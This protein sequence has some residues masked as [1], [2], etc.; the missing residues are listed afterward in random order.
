MAIIGP[1]QLPI[2][3]RADSTDLKFHILS[4]LGHPNVLVE[5]TE[6]QLEQILRSTAD[7]ISRYW[8]LQEKY[9]FFMTTP[10][11][12][13]YDIP[14][15]AYWIREVSWNPTTTRID[16]IFG[17]ESFL[18]CVDSEFMILGDDDKLH[19]VF[20]WNENWKAKTPYG[21]KK[22]KIKDHNIKHD[23]PKIKVDYGC[24]EII[25]TI[26]HPIQLS[27]GKWRQFDEL[28]VGDTLCGIKNNMKIQNLE[29]VKQNEAIAIR[30]LGSGVFYGCHKGEPV[31][32]H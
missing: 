31:L 1:S 14:S 22:L 29:H 23:L 8:P 25:A 6:P 32:I 13:E 18:F 9:A 10:L 24:G 26:N 30:A 3:F 11:R 17:A 20:D 21:N 4:Q 2:V 7:F 27:N 19:H 28:E 15:D 16:E 5:L 12:G